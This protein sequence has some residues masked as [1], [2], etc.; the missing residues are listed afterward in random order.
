MTRTYIKNR[1]NIYGKKKKQYFLRLSI[2]V[3]NLTIYKISQLQTKVL[4][5]L[6][7]IVETTPYKTIVFW[8]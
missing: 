1:Q 6:S 5:C 2:L 3:A 4:A 8:Y 7:E